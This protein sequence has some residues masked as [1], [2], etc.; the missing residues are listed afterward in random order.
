LL[1]Y[2]KEQVMECLFLLASI[3]AIDIYD[4]HILLVSKSLMEVINDDSW[5]D[6]FTSSWYSR[7]KQDF[8]GPFHL[9]SVLGR[10][11]QP[12]SFTSSQMVGLLGIIVS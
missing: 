12:V 2:I 3:V 11:Q 7:A 8:A 1:E 9:V 5:H 10:D 4:T 6:C